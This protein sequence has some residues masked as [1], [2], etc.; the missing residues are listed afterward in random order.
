MRDF[1]SEH[2]DAGEIDEADEMVLVA[3]CVPEESEEEEE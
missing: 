3:L 2:L 1:Y